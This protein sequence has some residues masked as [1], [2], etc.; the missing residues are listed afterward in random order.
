MLQDRG[1]RAPLAGM[2][3]QVETVLVFACIVQFGDDRMRVWMPG[4]TV[5]LA[6]FVTPNRFDV[7]V[8][9]S[10][11]PGPDFDQDRLAFAANSFVKADPPRAAVRRTQSA[12][13][14][15][16]SVENAL[17]SATRTIRH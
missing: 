12:I 6:D 13:V 4:H 15:A 16:E 8:I 1:K 9:L 2:D 14:H 17:S 5:K 3:H 11:R 7:A 10:W